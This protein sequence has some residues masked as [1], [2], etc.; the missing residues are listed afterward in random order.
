MIQL[1]FRRTTWAAAGRDQLEFWP[2]ILWDSTGPGC[3]IRCK[4]P[5]FIRVFHALL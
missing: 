3:K 2:V 1:D 5:F 4:N